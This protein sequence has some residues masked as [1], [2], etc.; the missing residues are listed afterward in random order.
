MRGGKIIKDY[1]DY[2]VMRDGRIW[3]IKSKIFLK[4][5]YNQKFY[6]RVKLY[7]DGIGT[8][9]FVHRLV[10]DAWNINIDDWLMYH[11]LPKSMKPKIQVDHDDWVRENNHA[12][13]LKW[14]TPSMN[15]QRN[16]NK[17][18]PKTERLPSDPF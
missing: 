15:M 18:W 8:R 5:F 14:V 1:P 9:F 4:P 13:N 6:L 11:G 10:Q 17:P 2:K 3:S 12:S 16:K 7:K